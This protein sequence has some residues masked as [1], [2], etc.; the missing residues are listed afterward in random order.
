M[1]T[2]PTAVQ[3]PAGG[4]ATATEWNTQAPYNMF[5]F[6]DVFKP[7]CGVF[8]SAAQSIPQTTFTTVTFDSETVDTDGQHSTVTNTSRIT[9]G[10]TLGW[11]RVW[12]M[13]PYVTNATGSRAAYIWQNGSSIITGSYTQIASGGGTFHT[14]VWTGPV[15]V[16]ATVSTDYVELRAW[17]NT[18]GALNTS[19]TTGVAPVFFAE[20]VGT[21][22]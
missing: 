6:L 17:Q 11:Y 12:G 10:G 16:Q 22:Q 3:V 9:I 8:N 4:K 15:Y 19:I 21:L 13:V 5:R 1:A 2:K 7:V 18:S 14:S 20:Y